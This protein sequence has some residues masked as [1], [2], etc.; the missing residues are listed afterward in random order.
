MDF[1]ALSD[2]TSSKIL[3]LLALLLVDGKPRSEQVQLLARAGFGS[4]EI[5]R[6]LGM[7]P[8]T[9]RVTLSRLRKRADDAA[10]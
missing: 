4:G 3:A 5:A 9:V 8:S 2:S 7:N 1:D 6:V 10:D